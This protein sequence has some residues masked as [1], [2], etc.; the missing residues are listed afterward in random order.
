MT[1]FKPLKKAMKQIRGLFVQYTD[2][3]KS[4]IGKAFWAYNK[5]RDELRQIQLRFSSHRSIFQRSLLLLNE[6]HNKDQAQKTKEI[7]EQAL[8]F[9]K[10]RKLEDKLRKNEAEKT[11]KELRNIKAMVK[12]LQSPK[13]EVTM[14]EKVI[15][16]DEIQEWLVKEKGMQTKE[17]KSF[18]GALSE[19]KEPQKIV[20]TGPRSSKVKMPGTQKNNSNDKVQLKV[21]KSTPNAVKSNVKPSANDSAKLSQQQKNAKDSKEE[22]ISIK[23]TAQKS[24]SK[25]KIKIDQGAADKSF[26]EGKR[27]N[28][29]QDINI[30][31]EKKIA[32]S[33][34]SKEG[35]IGTE[36]KGVKTG[37]TAKNQ[38]K[39]KQQGGKEEQKEF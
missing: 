13:P 7:K 33:S 5:G 29:S 16:E 38:G 6:G 11:A 9:A 24:R 1:Q 18:L 14:A 27:P 25:P 26:K 36:G 31:Q 37:E 17:A 12:K 35:V 34:T 30:V 20:A 22:K 19:K 39:T 32:P 2:L 28:K 15:T 21:K 4:L 10:E 3:T 23:G 8:K